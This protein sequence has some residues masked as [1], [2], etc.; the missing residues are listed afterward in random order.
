MCKQ[1]TVIV[2]VYNCAPYLRQCLESILNQT[3]KELEVILI[4]DGSTDSSL[5]ICKE[6][7]KQYE[8]IT[9]IDKQ[10][11]GVSSSRNI[12][13]DNATTEI[14]TF[15]DA[16]DILDSKAIE[17]LIY[18]M[19]KFKVDRVSAGYYHLFDSG[20]FIVRKSR[21]QDGFYENKDLLP[22]IIDDGTLSGFL[23][24][25]VHNSLYKRS[26]LN[27]NAIRFHEHI[28]YNEDSL[29]NFEYALCSNSTY[30][31]KE[32]PTYYY[33]KHEKS[34]T[35]KRPLGEH[36]KDLR[37]ILV[38]LDFDKEKYQFE[39]QMSRRI[40][41][42]TL[43]KILDI[44]KK[45]DLKVGVLHIKKELSRPDLLSGLKSLDL[46]KMNK[47]KKCYYLMMKFKTSLLLYLLTKYLLPFLSKKIA[48]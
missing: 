34:S 12:G 32:V 44:S 17:T 41:T 33:R 35:G 26:I 11:G 48:R 24:S 39:L 19:L 22:Y 30:T 42:E 36:Y 21:I 10:N 28:K 2:P 16:D 1:I 23:L 40:A 4:N 9:V 46:T 45:M 47:Y 29:F 3:Y 20:L 6:Y 38:A 31:L 14:I 7:E 27:K 13:L 5:E 25:G 15:V 37:K 18:Y 43:W 8:N